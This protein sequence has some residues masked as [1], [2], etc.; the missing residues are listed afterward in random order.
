MAAA[1]LE[2][3]WAR[4]LHKGSCR[5]QVE[6]L[7]IT[8]LSG[9]RLSESE[10][11]GL[12]VFTVEDPFQLLVEAVVD[13]AI[14][15]L[16]P[17]GIISTWNSGAER[18]KGYRAEEIIGEHFSILYPEEAVLRG[19]PASELA[20][21]S[22]EGRHEDEGWRLRKD[23]SRLW[24]NDVITALRAPDGSLIGFGKVTRDLTERRLAEQSLR[25]SNERDAKGV[26]EL[27]SANSYLKSIFNASSLVS[28]IA[29]DPVGTITIFNRGAEL[30]LGYGSE[31]V[32]GKQTPALFHLADE[33]E[34]RGRALSQVLG[35]RVHGFEVFTSCIDVEGYENEEWIYIHKDGHH[36]IVSLSLSVVRGETGEIIGFLG[37][38]EDVTERRRAAKELATAYAHV[39][40]VLESTSNSVVTISRE[41]KLL[42]GNRK[43]LESL[44]DFEVGKNYWSCFPAVLGSP[45]ETLLRKAMSERCEIEYE[46]YFAPYETWYRA[47]GF[48]TDEGLSI[49][50]SDITEEKKM[51]E[52]LD[53]EQLLREKRIEGL[54]HMAGGLAHEISN[55]LAIIHGRATD[56]RDLAMAEAPVAAVEVRTACDSILKTAERASSILRGLRGFAREANQDPM[57]LASIYDIA[58]E[59]LELQQSRFDRNGIEVRVALD[60]GIP[61]LLCRETQ[62]GQILTN[63]LNNA[64]DAI[65]QSEVKGADR[66]VGLTAASRDG[67]ITVE[68]T[69]SGPGIA[70]HFKA[71]LMEPFFT[72]K[73][74]GLGMGVGLSL[75]R[76]IA[77]DHGGTL[78]L[79]SDRKNTCFQLVLPITQDAG[80]QEAGKQ[81][82]EPAGGAS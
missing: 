16:D 30:M 20:A 18:I 76:A 73:E 58:D 43:A 7:P 48:P 11:A 1:K 31:E 5:K 77:Q 14:F 52:Q 8:E 53:V 38:A 74:L 2:S 37:V 59:S 57:A 15:L 22:A 70:D 72:T 62:I 79:C 64:F 75:S 29:T 25:E 21:A 24:V 81:E 78:M 51:Q 63:L 17:Q 4:N 82:V 12:G 9:A 71:H 33:V 32:I 42:Y 3:Q 39:S 67:K 6:M 65:V 27:A 28:I 36:I 41:W 56:L 50:F 34:E 45:T 19:V 54:S 44:P 66:W 13:Y 47:Q 26:V 68:V 49:F 23:G 80:K 61:P 35:R 69:D 55:P 60:P 40:S 46:I 10:S